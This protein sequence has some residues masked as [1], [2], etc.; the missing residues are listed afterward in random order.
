MQCYMS[1]TCILPIIW[2]A[3]PG[4]KQGITHTHNHLKGPYMQGIMSY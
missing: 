3:T 4:V 2:Y 1:E